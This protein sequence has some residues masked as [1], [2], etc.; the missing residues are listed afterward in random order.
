MRKWISYLLVSKIGVL[1]KCRFL[2]FPQKPVA[3]FCILTEIGILSD[4]CLTIWLIGYEI[5]AL[6]QIWTLWVINSSFWWILWMAKWIATQKPILLLSQGCYK[7]KMLFKA[8]YVFKKINKNLFY[9]GEKQIFLLW[10]TL[11]HWCT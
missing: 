3:Q 11:K 5:C 9:S 10:F 8:L 2:Y 4:I 7:Y 1:M 6:G